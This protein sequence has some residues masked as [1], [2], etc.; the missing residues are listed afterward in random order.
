MCGIAGLVADAADVRDVDVMLAAIEHRGPDEYGTYV[1]DHAA[2]GTARLSIIDLA[3]GGQPIRHA[4]TGA[5]IVFNGEIFN[6]LELR[7]ALAKDGY[8]FQTHSDTE[9]VLALYLKYGEQFPTHLNGQFAIAIWDPRDRTLVLARD[10]FGICPLFYHCQP[11]ALLAFGSEL[12]AILTL[13]R[14]PRRLCLKALDQI[15]TFWTPVAGASV[16]EG[17]A[18]LRPG[19]LLIY[20]NGMAR[21]HAYWQWPF[22]GLQETSA[23]T[24]DH[25]REE[26]LEQ[27]SRAVDIR[28]RADVEVGSYLSG[29]IDSSAI[30][31]M[32]SKLRP[33]GVR[34]Y[35]V[36]FADESYD[37]R[38]YQEM[39]A[40][41]L[42]TRHTAVVCGAEDIASRFARV[43]WHAEAP[44]FR[45]APAPLNMLSERVHRDGIKVVLTGE[46]ADEILLGYDIFREVKIR[47]FWSR[48]PG[49]H[50][51][52]QLLKRLYAYLPQFKDPRFAGLAIESF[53]TSLVS[54]SP[55]YSHL[56]RWSNNAANKVYF[57]SAVRDALAGYDAT[58]DLASGLPRDYADADD[59]DR[60]QYLE[61]TTLL[62]GYLL[63]S[64]GDRMAMSNSVEGRFPFLDHE[65]VGFASRLP[66][67]HK[68]TGLRDKRILRESM[69]S[70]LPEEI[71][72]RKKFA[73]Q[74]PE[75]RAFIRKDQKAGPLADEYMSDEM[76]RHVGL[77]NPDP[78]RMLLRK[79]ELSELSRMGTRDN[80]AFVQVLSTHIF[81]RQFI[82]NDLRA[83][84]AARAAALSFTTRIDGRAN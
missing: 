1:D 59:V 26:F 55:F 63:A 35:S 67:A 38:R 61:L 16:I 50:A 5:V 34:T 42:K 43:I 29:G 60:A 56:I 58:A 70:L 18:E 17:I 57:S 51:R 49:S 3:G 80:M 71:C 23:Q 40:T 37:E 62:R 31:A 12:K 68:L 75:I 4:A 74:A 22:P 69:R 33:G 2:M 21:T 65:F 36:G 77:F 73:Y 81:H 24:F 82:D 64:Q 79:I 84:A 32:A 8:R 20:R 53:R 48:Q 15:F 9:V 41:C 45:T 47:R 27:F 72:N 14:V 10:R 13:G 46:G 39:V 19:H 11:G 54:S 83:P 52:P 44:I 28:L 6:Y 76:V 30:V 66:R 7:D 25:A 78:V